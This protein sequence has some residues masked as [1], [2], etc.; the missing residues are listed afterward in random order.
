[1]P[2]SRFP[3]PAATNDASRAIG[4]TW[5]LRSLGVSGSQVIVSPRTAGDE[6]QAPAGT[7]FRSPL[8]IIRA[9]PTSRYC[10]TSPHAA[11]SPSYGALASGSPPRVSPSNGYSPTT[12]TATYRT[13]FAK[14]ARGSDSG[15]CELGHA[16]RKPTAK[17][18]DSSKR[19]YANGRTDA[20][21]NPASIVLESS[22]LGGATPQTAPC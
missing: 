10:K 7:M 6:A 1:V 8:M 17:P 14:P 4:C 13:T 2:W 21:T 19:C 18:N 15:I 3:L 12:V 11:A 16:R 5:T 20:I 9:S 22:C